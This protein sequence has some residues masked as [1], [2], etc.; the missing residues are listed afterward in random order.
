MNNY[1]SDTLTAA[2][3]GL[4]GTALNIKS[5]NR[6]III[7]SLINHINNIDLNSVKDLPT[8]NWLPIL[9][10]FLAPIIKDIIKM[11]I[12]KKFPNLNK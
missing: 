4:I 8:N 11:L 9:L 1:I 6:D 2:T 10:T 5:D 3:G 7:D 12:V